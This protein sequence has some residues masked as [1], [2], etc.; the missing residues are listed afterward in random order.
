[1]PGDPCRR[2]RRLSRIPVRFR[3]YYAH[4]GTPVKVLPNLPIK[5]FGSTFP[6]LPCEATSRMTFLVD[7]VGSKDCQQLKDGVVS[8]HGG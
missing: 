4:S 5:V 1:M 2:Q 3:H 6:G 7:P 8:Q